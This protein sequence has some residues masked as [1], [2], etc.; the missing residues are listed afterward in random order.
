VAHVAC[1]NHGLDFSPEEFLESR[2]QIDLEFVGIFEN[3][4]VEQDLVGFAEAEVELVLMEKF[5]VCLNTMLV[6][7]HCRLFWFRMPSRA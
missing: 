3:L 2:N 6:S 1:R 4:R 5:L 7:N